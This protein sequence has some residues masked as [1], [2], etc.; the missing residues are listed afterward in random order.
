MNA[1]GLGYDPDGNRCVSGAEP[2]GIG[3]ICA[4][5]PPYEGYGFDT[6]RGSPKVGGPRG[7]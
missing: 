4:G 1:I 6:C 3:L 2:G 5:G 7:E